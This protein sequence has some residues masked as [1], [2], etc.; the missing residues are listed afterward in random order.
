MGPRTPVAAA[1]WRARALRTR[2]GT[3]SGAVSAGD[4]AVREFDP[5]AA[6]TNLGSTRP[7]AAIAEIWRPDRQ[8]DAPYVGACRVHQ[9]AAFS[10]RRPR[11][12]HDRRSP[13]SLPEARAK[14]EPT[15]RL[16]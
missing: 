1:D 12:R 13:R 7:A 8:R 15:S 5:V 6:R 10:R 14:A 3:R 2:R 9:A 16:E 4:G 11:I